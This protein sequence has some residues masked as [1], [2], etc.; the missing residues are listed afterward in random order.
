MHATDSNL[1]ASWLRLRREG[2]TA[3]AETVL[4]SMLSGVDPAEQ[5]AEYDAECKA[6]HCGVPVRYIDRRHTCGTRCG[7]SSAA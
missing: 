4:R 5:V 1:F 2:R 6:T 7:D 3:E